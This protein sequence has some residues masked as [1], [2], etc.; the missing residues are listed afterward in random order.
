M[1]QVFILL[2]VFLATTANGQ[3]T[4]KD[5]T[6]K[7]VYANKTSNAAAPA[8]FING[9][10]SGNSLQATFDPEFI[11]SLHIVK[12]EIQIDGVQYNGQIHIK[13]KSSYNPKFITLTALKNK[14]TNLKN[15]SVV[16]MINEN[17]INADYDKYIVDEN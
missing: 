4:V 5:S 6:L 16:F 7:V 14:Y 11:D 1:K 10:L 3:I 8:W 13:T 12:G 15:K 9:K 2:V 17:I